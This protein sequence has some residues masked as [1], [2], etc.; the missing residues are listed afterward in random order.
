Y[1]SRRCGD[2]IGRLALLRALGFG[3]S[4]IVM[5]GKDREL[6][7]TAR[8]VGQSYGLRMGPGLQKPWRS[9]DISTAV[10][11]EDNVTPAAGPVSEIA[12]GF[13]TGEFCFHYQPK[14][15]L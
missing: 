12:R 13:A 4:V 14:F 5:S 11:S 7:E 6:V 8:R 2:A 3:G 1:L 9:G 15:D 10:R